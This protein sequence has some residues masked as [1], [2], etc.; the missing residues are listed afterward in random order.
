M[1]LPQSDAIFVK[2]YHAET[3]EAFCD[4]HIEVFAF[5]GGVPQSILYDDTQASNRVVRSNEAFSSPRTECGASP[6][7]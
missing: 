4:G 7:R 6:S 3:A 1:D 2:A 5:F